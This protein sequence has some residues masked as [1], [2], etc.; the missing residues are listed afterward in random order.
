MAWNTERGGTAA[1][2]L[3]AIDWSVTAMTE[4]AERFAFAG[5]WDLPRAAAAVNETV[6][7]ITLVDATLVRYHRQD[8]ED[9]L[10][11]G[12]RPARRKTVETLAG[13]RY[14]RNRLGESAGAAEFIRFAL[15]ADGAAA[16]IWK[17]LPQPALDGMAASS[18][19]WEISRY[20]S[21]QARLANRDVGLI[22]TRCAA[23]LERAATTAAAAETSRAG[24]AP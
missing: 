16:W 22:L 1:A 17:P 13:L 4:A 19:D 24:S 9:T 12:V 6:W 20:R 14:V 21:Y 7:W 23:F 15:D 18:R 11:S 2:P 10:A 8:Y 5:T 3:A